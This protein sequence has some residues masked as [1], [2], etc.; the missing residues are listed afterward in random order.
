MMLQRKIINEERKIK[1]KKPMILG[2]NM[3]TIFHHNSPDTKFVEIILANYEIKVTCELAR[4]LI[5]S[6]FVGR[7]ESN[8]TINLKLQCT[9]NKL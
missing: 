5:Q 7:T 6:N 3:C 8:N 2:C 4:S 9:S 1:E